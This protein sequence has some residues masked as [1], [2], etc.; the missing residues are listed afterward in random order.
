MR[1]HMDRSKGAYIINIH[2]PET[3]D[4]ILELRKRM[5]NAYIHFVKDYIMTLPI[6][7]AEK[8]KLYIKVNKSM[9]KI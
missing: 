6:S 2:Y 8:N 7:D 4:G 1:N 3:Q 5:G 9:Q